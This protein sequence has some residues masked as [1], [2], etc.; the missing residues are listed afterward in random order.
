[1]DITTLGI[2]VSKNIF[3]VIGTNRAGKPLIKDKYTRQK[4][5]EF[6]AQHPPCLIGM[7][8]CPGAQHLARKFEEYGHQVKL[9]PAQ[10]V[11]PYVKSNKDDY[12]DAVAIAEAVRSTT[13]RFVTTKTTEQHD[14]QALHRVRERLVRT[15]TSVICQLRS[16]ML[17]NGVAVRTGRVALAKALPDILEDADQPLSDR[18]RA[19]VYSLREHWLFLDEQIKSVSGDLERIAKSRDDCRRLLTVPG[20]GPL[21]ATAL[22]ASIG[23]GKQFSRGRELSAWLGLVP[24]EHSTGGKQRLLG[25]SKRGSSYLRKLVIHGA[26]SC[27]LNMNRSQHKM[28]PWIDEMANRGTHR[29]VIVVAIANKLARICWAVM[30]DGDVYHCTR[31]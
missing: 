6:V 5:A 29:I 7:E 25:I 3:H 13:L 2:D 19:L 24:R 17:E 16:F 30:R 31:A 14:L 15:R 21:V 28:G 23:S 27:Y 11:K 18:V 22:V 26:R 4:L 9:M 10:F 12:N 8:A 20:V 1:M